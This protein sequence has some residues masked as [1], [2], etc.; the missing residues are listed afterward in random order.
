[1]S[2]GAS[3]ASHSV[4]SVDTFTELSALKQSTLVDGDVVFVRE[5]ASFWRLSKESTAATSGAVRASAMG[6]RWILT[7]SASGVL[8]LPNI[9][10]L[11]AFDDTLLSEY[12]QVFVESVR[13]PF[14]LG[15]FIEFPDD[16]TTAAASSGT[17]T[18]YRTAV[19][20][21]WSARDQWFVD[22]VV[23]NDEN[24][25][26]SAL[27]PLASYRELTRRTY[28]P[29][30]PVSDASLRVT[31][32]A[33]G[34][35]YDDEFISNKSVEF[36]GTPTVVA[37][38]NVTGSTAVVY[39][40]YEPQTLNADNLDWAERNLLRFSDDGGTSFYLAGFKTLDL[41]GTYQVA[42]WNDHY[43]RVAPSANEFNPDLAQEVSLPYAGGLFKAAGNGSIFEFQLCDLSGSYFDMQACSLNI[44][45]CQL[46]SAIVESAFNFQITR[47]Y[48][49]NTSI[50]GTA[51]FDPIGKSNAA[52]F[53]ASSFLRQMCTLSNVTVSTF[54]DTAIVGLA[55]GAANGFKLRYANLLVEGG[56]EVKNCDAPFEEESSQ[57][58]VTFQIDSDDNYYVF[59]GPGCTRIL[60]LNYT[61]SQMIYA[62]PGAFVASG[63]THL[64]Q[65][66]N[67]AGG[68]STG[69]ALPAAAILA[70]TLCGIFHA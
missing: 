28:N 63:M 29:K 8:I 25:G 58:T 10:A 40:P 42:I 17:K 11:K 67:G 36:V 39:D 13:S 35:N 22:A 62:D 32:G 43:E 47:S 56:V 34:V 23:G 3:T 64:W 50:N 49:F 45:S 53:I 26:A 6:G 66:P 12:A 21:L 69:D 2:L 5:E 37:E 24:D 68:T 20:E 52:S 15:P 38:G 51:N 27:S 61:N 65:T 9:T 46:N 41:E 48:L 16:I 33:N 59:G 4:L 19:P 31:I 55:A 30:A 1:M 60:K 44:D 70:T 18:W 14:Y 57:S 7:Y 54:G